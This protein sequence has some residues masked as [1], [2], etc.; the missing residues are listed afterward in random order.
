MS[1]CYVRTGRFFA[2]RGARARLCC[3]AT[4]ARHPVGMSTAYRAPPGSRRLP[5]ALWV[6]I[7]VGCDSGFFIRASSSVLWVTTSARG[8]VIPQVIISELDVLCSLV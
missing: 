2:A 3:V 6:V 8:N 1:A 5:S 7:V 4:A